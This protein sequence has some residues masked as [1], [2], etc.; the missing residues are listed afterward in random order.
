[1]RQVFYS[2]GSEMHKESNFHILLLLNASREWLSLSREARTLFF[3]Q[4]LQ[5]AFARVQNTVK[6]RF[7]DTEYFHARVSDFIYLEAGNLHDYQLLM[8]MLRDTELYT[9]PYFHLIDIII[10]QENA[11]ETFNQ[12]LAT[13][14]YEA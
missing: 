13:G 9:S 3:R 14:D 10:G 5:P 11:F 1:M 4:K 12:L 8:E 6:V 7:F 2:T